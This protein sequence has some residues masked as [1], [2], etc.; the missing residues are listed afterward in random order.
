MIEL[1]NDIQNKSIR[2]LNQILDD[3]PLYYENMQNM[4]YGDQPDWNDIL[5]YLAELEKEIN[6]L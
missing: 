5:E 1:M 3:I 2:T 6:S 4:I